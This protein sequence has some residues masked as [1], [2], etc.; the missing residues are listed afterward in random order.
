[1]YWHSTSLCWMSAFYF[2]VETWQLYWTQYGFMAK[3]VLLCFRGHYFWINKHCLQTERAARLY[4]KHVHLPTPNIVIYCAAKYVHSILYDSCCMK[5]PPRRNLRVRT[6]SH[7]G[8]GLCVK[9]IAVQII[10]QSTVSCPSKHVEMAIKCHHCVAIATCRWWWGTAQYV[11]RWNPCPP[12]AST[13]PAYT[14]LLVMQKCTSESNN[15]EV[16]YV[17]YKHH[18]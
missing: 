9:V 5:Q 17:M 10:R 1:M 12:E 15:P 2:S 11:F 14:K 13:H 3:T 8:P 16:S 6:W 18:A 4:L 7:N